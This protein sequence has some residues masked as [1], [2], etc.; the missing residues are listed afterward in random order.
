M[1]NPFMPVMGGPQT[2]Q[3]GPANM[4]QAFQNFMQQN[5]G[6]DPNDMIQQMLSSGRINQQ[7]LNQVQQ[8]ARQMEGTLGGLKGMFGFR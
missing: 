4:M 2:P 3:G 5:Q 1:P 8:M 7:Q 6:R